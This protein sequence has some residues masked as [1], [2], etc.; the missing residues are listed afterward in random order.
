MTPFISLGELMEWNNEAA[1]FWRDHFEANPALLDLPCGING[2]DNVQELVRHIW[3]AE[4]RWAQ[5]VGG[6]PPV[7]PADLPTGPLAALFDLHEQANGVWRGLLGDSDHDWTQSFTLDVAWLPAEVQTISHRKAMAHAMLHGQRHWA[8][9][10]TLLRN[11][12][13]PSGFQGDVL[14]SRC[15]G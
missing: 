5:R 4:L 12:G 2:A 3:G 10:T 11:A 1:K 14:F 9:L 13:Y 15:L 8:Q 6:V 7:A